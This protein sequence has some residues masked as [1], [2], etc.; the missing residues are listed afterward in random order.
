[1]EGGNEAGADGVEPGS[2]NLK[3]CARELV[4]T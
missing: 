4:A 1:M 2:R 3:T